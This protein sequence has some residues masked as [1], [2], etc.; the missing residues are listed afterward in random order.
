M[1]V[2]DFQ[3]LYRYLVDDFLI[4]YSEKLDKKDFRVKTEDIART[5]IGKMVYLND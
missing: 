4:N 5:K 2:C 3:E 1:E